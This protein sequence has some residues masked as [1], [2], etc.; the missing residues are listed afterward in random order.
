MPSATSPTVTWKVPLTSL[1]I[2]PEEE[3]AAVRVLRSGWLSMGPEVEAFEHEFAAALDVPHAVAV[4]NA[5]DGLAICYDAVGVTSG[6]R[7]AMPALTFVASMNVALRRNEDPLLIDITSEDDLTMSATDLAEKLTPDTRLIVTMPY[8]GF[9]PDMDAIRKLSSRHDV[10]VLEDACH[11][12]LARCRGQWLGTIGEAGVF[13][14]YSNKN[15]TTGEGGMIVTRDRVLAER[16]RLIRSH[17]MT[18]SSYDHYNSASGLSGPGEYDVRVAGHNF[19][20]DDL[21]AAIGRE[22][23][24]KLP[25][26][27]LRRRQVAESMREQLAARCPDLKVPFSQHD[28]AESSHH[29]FAALLPGGVDRRLFMLRLAEAGVQTSIHYTPLHRFAHT[30]GIWPEPPHLPM[31]ESIEKRLV[32]LPLGP[33]MTEAQMGIV[34]DAVAGALECRTKA[35]VVGV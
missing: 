28:P 25:D 20:M 32:T 5:T 6:Q 17:G 7:V 26:A 27:N 11:G 34:V 2:G 21:R 24:R 35:Q 9:A 23:L 4:A 10:P 13:S 15:M 1:T 14:F 12:V 19:R 18:R 31:L 22:Q 30:A 8:G 16:M 33:R 3:A 29:L